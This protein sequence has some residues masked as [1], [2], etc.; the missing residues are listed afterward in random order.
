MPMQMA[1][2]DAGLSLAAGMGVLD[3]SSGSLGSV[4]Y[5]S[6]P[7][8]RLTTCALRCATGHQ[9]YVQVSNWAADIE[10]LM[11]P[12][13]GSCLSQLAMDVMLSLPLLCTPTLSSIQSGLT[14]PTEGGMWVHTFEDHYMRI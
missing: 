8:F 9:R 11:H 13:A 7:L 1:G 12:L 6:Y 3:R 14:W 4:S 5:P 10:G 2:Q